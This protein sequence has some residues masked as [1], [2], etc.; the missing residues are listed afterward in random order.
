MIL[1]RL[2]VIVGVL[3]LYGAPGA[4]F[5]APSAVLA[6]GWVQVPHP[7]KGKGKKCVADT[8]F[9]R[10]NHMKMLLHQRDDTMHQGIRTKRFSLNECITCHAVKGADNKPV[11]VKSPKHFCRQCHDYAAVRIDC[12]EC[13]ASRPDPKA[14]K[15]ALGPDFEQ[16]HVAEQRRKAAARRLAAKKAADSVAAELAA[17]SG[18]LRSAQQ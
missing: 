10:R 17:L 3:G 11:T 6:G 7:P 12:F 2:L 4:A 13:H 14:D 18:F 8:D 16:K 1:R 9:M 5:L 15:A